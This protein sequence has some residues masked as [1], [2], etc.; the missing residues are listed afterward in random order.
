M[1]G[2]KAYSL[3]L[4]GQA[5][6]RDAAGNS[7]G[8]VLAQPKR[9][10]LLAYLVLA[11]PRGFHRRDL[12]LSLFWPEM[13]EA[14][15]RNALRQA[16]FHLRELLPDVIL[17]RPDGS[18]GVDRDRIDCDVIDFERNA[19]A[20]PG[21]L[22]PVF[23]IGDAEPFNEWL[24]GY[25]AALRRR[26]ETL[27][28]TNGAA[29]TT[30]NTHDRSGPVT[31]AVTGF[32]NLTG[33]PS[34]DHVGQIAAEAVIAELTAARL[35]T[36]VSSSGT[37]EFTFMISGSFRADASGLVFHAQLQ[38]QSGRVV[39]VITDSVGEPA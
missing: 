22:L 35:A 26:Y 23:S 11:S 28:S 5:D 30:R 27:A 1:S 14:R 15:A 12:L 29:G 20:Y 4:L 3:K 18:I 13:P 33:D 19:A 31:V 10:A 8:A 9:F 38:D 32:R 39:G 24:D 37:T 25:R 34:R 17:S 21:D 16:L 7:V 36:A 2:G 6:L